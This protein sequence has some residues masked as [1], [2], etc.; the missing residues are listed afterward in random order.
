MHFRSYLCT[1]TFFVPW[2]LDASIAKAQPAANEQTPSTQP[3]AAEAKTPQPAASKPESPSEQLE[4]VEL[5][6]PALDLT[7]EELGQL[8][9]VV[10]VGKTERTTGSAHHIGEE[11]LEKFENDDVHRILT[12]VPG[13]YVRGEDGFGLR[14]NIGLRGASAERSK[15][16]NLMEDG[17]LFAPAPYSAPAAYYFPLVTRM[18]AVEV[19]KG[20]SAIRYGPNTVGGAVNL[21]TRSIP[22][23]SGGG[24]DVALGQFNYEKAHLHYGYGGDQ[25]GFLLEG[26]RIESDGF[27]DIDGGDNSGFERQDFMLKW[28]VNS[29]PDAANFQQLSLKLGYASESS[30]ETYLG[31]TDSDFRETP[32]RRYAASQN[33]AMDWYRGQ[34][35]V[36]HHVDLG[37]DA[38]LTT[39]AY[40]H[41]FVRLWNR[42]NSLGGEDSIQDVLA[43][44]TSPTHRDA[45]DVLT[46]ERDS[47][48]NE[49]LLTL[50]GNR[51]EFVSQGIQAVGHLRFDHG[52]QGEPA[53]WAQDIEFGARLHYDEVLR[54]HSS[55]AF[56]MQGGRLESE[57]PSSSRVERFETASTRAVALHA[58]D[59]L[60]WGSWLVAPGIRAELI[61]TQLDNEL[62]D[63]SDSNFH[64]VFIPGVGAR[65]ALTSE[66]AVL[67][68]VHQGFSPPAPSSDDT[69]DIPPEKSINYELGG[70]FVSPSTHAE[71]I[72]F[73]N[74]YSNFIEDCSSSAGCNDPRLNSRQFAADEARVFGVELSARH[75]FRVNRA[76]ELPLQ[77]AYTFTQAQV[78]GSEQALPFVP[79]HQGS[80]TVG[81]T[82][83]TWATHASAT[84]L[85]AMSEDPVSLQA[86]IEVIRLET[87]AALIFDLS[88]D[89][90][91]S[92]SAKF[93]AKLD[94]V[95]D[96]AY[97]ASR[98]PFGARPGRP[99]WFQAGLKYQF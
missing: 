28:R 20:P 78:V 61:T 51:R 31:L 21:V 59:E 49:E 56:V 90:H 39:T 18:R 60:T 7:E 35:Q 29:D 84:Y 80:A 77:A 24:L 82:T 27:K 65:Y 16:V 23:G 92:E 88:A 8:D 32:N 97:I 63:T 73:F 17:V 36:T 96:T 5:D 6:E 69:E 44:P 38:N 66:L 1:A 55:S 25:W 62:D 86:P 83:A 52:S 98:R 81:L 95:L 41:R 71:L 48:T 53:H 26:A 33:D 89:L 15:K 47:L 45:Y 91:I 2:A 93:Y 46:G 3:Q 70:Q 30:N 64:A 13:V 68:G 99:R 79:R 42:F 12:R 58:V 10:I 43:R 74:N 72:G 85:G 40:R 67:G 4:P 75:A 94:N 76:I 14:P 50:L 87:D 19:F 37:P 9:T 34:V 54:F 57:G 22:F 11:E